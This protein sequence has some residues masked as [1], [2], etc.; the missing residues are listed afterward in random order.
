MAQNL[1]RFLFFF[2]TQSIINVFVCRKIKKSQSRK[3]NWSRFSSVP[4]F[5]FSSLHLLFFR[6]EILTRTG[7]SFVQG[8]PEIFFSF[9]K[10][11]F[12]SNLPSYKSDGC[13]SGG[14]TF[15]EV[16]IPWMTDETLPLSLS[17][18]LF[19][20][21]RIERGRERNT[22]EKEW[23][24]ERGGKSAEQIREGGGRKTLKQRWWL[25]LMQRHP[26]ANEEFVSCAL[27]GDACARTDTRTHPLFLSLSLTHTHT[28]SSSNAYGGRNLDCSERERERERERTWGRGSSGIR[29]QM[30]VG[31][32]TYRD[33]RS[34]LMLKPG[35][36]KAGNKQGVDLANKNQSRGVNLFQLVSKMPQRLEAWNQMRRGQYSSADL[37]WPDL[38]TNVSTRLDIHWR[39]RCGLSH[40]CNSKQ[41]QFH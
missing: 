23:E 4:F 28:R 41:A 10:L 24:R 5:R 6:T 39:H 25:F 32:L 36:T 3:L 14:E 31:H 15:V 13:T 2:S 18:S 11:D 7:T 1:S 22:W 38:K 8:Y 20:S 29:L 40:S 30:W 17:L 21:R 27:F 9:S 33:L 34:H 16:R 26:L 12:K 37:N 19:L 35:K